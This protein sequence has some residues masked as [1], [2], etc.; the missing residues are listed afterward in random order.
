MSTPEVCAHRVQHRPGLEADGFLG[1]PGQ[2][3]G[4]GAAGEADQQAAG[5]GVPVGCAQSGQGRH[6]VDAAVVGRLRGEGADLR[7]RVDDPQGVAQPL[8]RA[9]AHEDRALKGVGERRRAAAPLPASDGARV[10]AEAPRHGREQAVLRPG[11]TRAHVHEQEAARPVGVLA[12][13]RP[14]RALSEQ[15]RLLVAGHA[16]DRHGGAQPLRLGRARRAPTTG[17]G[18]AGSSGG[19]RRGRAGRRPS[20]GLCRSSSM[21]REALL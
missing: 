12:V 13:A 8:D 20:R 19:R 2:V 4:P 15:R 11:W 21:V 9:A 6:E 7:R 3:L 16:G 1:R 17:T 10:R 5:V 14:Q 18:G